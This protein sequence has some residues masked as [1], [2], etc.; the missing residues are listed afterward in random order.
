MAGIV[1]SAAWQSNPE[2]SWS[3][4]SVACSRD[5]HQGAGGAS[6]RRQRERE[7]LDR[8]PVYGEPG[9]GQTALF[10]SVRNAAPSKLHSA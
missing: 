3:V 7:V 9:I 4:T 2:N 10:E 8:L 1:V 5:G 6:R